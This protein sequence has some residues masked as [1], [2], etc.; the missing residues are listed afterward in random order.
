MP[1]CGKAI[2]LAGAMMF[3][4]FT[5]AGKAVAQDAAALA[6][7]LHATAAANSIDTP[8]LLPWHLKMDVQLFDAKGKP[9]E[10]GSV[11]EWWASPELRRVTYT[12]PSYTV[13]Q[14]HN[15][16]GLFVTKSQ[17]Y[18]PAILDDLLE[19]VVHPMPHESEIDDSKPDLRKEKF[20]NVAL[21][22][23]MLDQ[24]LKNVAYPPLGLFPTFCLD[25]GK[26]SLRISTELGSLMFVRNRMGTFQGRSVAVDLAGES[27]GRKVMSAHVTALA[28]MQIADADFTP[29][30]D[31]E[32]VTAGAVRVGS[33][34][35]AGKI[36][37]QVQPVYPQ[38]AKDNRVSGVVVMHAIIGRDGR[39]EMLHLVST[40]DPNLAIA[41]I[42]AV[43][44][45]TYKPY[46]LNGV[47]TEVETTINV[48]FTFGR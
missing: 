26:D 36:L 35:M 22:C 34:T 44:K 41:A 25:P 20:G 4:A 18:E 29:G 38:I 28:S 15:K 13:T 1:R 19:Q 32:S 16:D 10:Q 8:G 5:P 9:I 47:P 24:P 23:V 40:P 43:R 46:T 14:L 11:E 30:A 12:M 39:I 31:M 6:A 42:A 3:C 27:D 21:D 33:G 2:S 7:R 17:V 45:W 37:T 48:N